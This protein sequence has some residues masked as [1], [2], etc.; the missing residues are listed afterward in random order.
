MRPDRRKRRPSG[1]TTS[2]RGIAMAAA[3]APAASP[4]SWPS[5]QITKK[6]RGLNRKVASVIILICGWSVADSEARK[7]TR[8]FVFM[9]GVIQKYA[10]LPVLNR[11]QGMLLA[12][13]VPIGCSMVYYKLHR[14]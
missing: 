10:C 13:K 9:E 14:N 12:R 6:A 4:S 2:T 1:S 8:V 3:A 7:A 5:R 11:V